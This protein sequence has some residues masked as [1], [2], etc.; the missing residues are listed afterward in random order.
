MNVFDNPE[1]DDDNDWVPSD[2][3][4][5]DWVPSNWLGLLIA[6][7]DSLDVEEVTKI[8]IDQKCDELIKKIENILG[9]T[10]SK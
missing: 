1:G 5:D 9:K 8:N 7:L 10:T 4:D 6:N 3:D 2:D